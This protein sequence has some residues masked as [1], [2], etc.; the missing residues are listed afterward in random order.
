MREKN[1]VLIIPSNKK[2]DTLFNILSLIFDE[3]TIL[4]NRIIES[5]IKLEWAC[6]TRAEVMDEKY[7]DLFM[8]AGCVQV[9]FGLETAN[10]E[11]QSFRYV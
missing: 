1:G 9:H 7:L 10:T 11:T 3:A 5:D 6:L 4:L 2:G 8:K